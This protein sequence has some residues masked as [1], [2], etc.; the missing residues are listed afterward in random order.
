M[1][2]RNKPPKLFGTPLSKCLEDEAQSNVDSGPINRRRAR[3]E[4]NQIVQDEQGRRR[5]HGAFTG[6]FS[7]G[8]YNTV[9]TVQGFQPKSFKSQRGAG[10]RDYASSSFDHLPEDY[11]DEEDFGEFGIAPKKVRLAG[12]FAEGPASSASKSTAGLPIVVRDSIGEQILRCMTRN[13]KAG[14]LETTQPIIQ[15]NDYH[16]LGYEPLKPNRSSTTTNDERS[17]RNPLVASTKSGMQLKISGEA[18]GVGVL[19]QDEDGFHDTDE[20][21]YDDITNYDFS[22]LQSSAAKDFGRRQSESRVSGKPPDASDPHHLSGFVLTTDPD[23]MV[24][25]DNEC[26]NYPLPVIEDGWKIPVRNEP[27]LKPPCESDL[28]KKNID[29]YKN[30]VSSLDNK[31]TR[32]EF[33]PSKRVHD[34]ESRSGLVPYSDLK[35]LVQPNVQIEVPPQCSNVQGVKITRKV[36]EWRPC[37]LL[38]KRFG[39]ENP[40]PD[41]EFCGVR[42]SDLAQR[43]ELSADQ[44]KMT[45]EKVSSSDQT[46]PIELRKSIFNVSFDNLAEADEVQPVE[47]EYEPQ[48][49]E[50]G[51]PEGGNNL[52]GVYQ[53]D[54]TGRDAGEQSRMDH[55]QDPEVVVVDV[56]KKEPE[57]IVLSSGSSGSSTGR[58]SSAKVSSDE[59]ADVYGP[60]L[61]PS[62]QTLQDISRH[63]SSHKRKRHKSKSHKGKRKARSKVDEQ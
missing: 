31:F 36:V 51:S 59:D 50:L 14:C 2:N 12:Q 33:D 19:N 24:M 29:L 3:L 35:A 16:G 4:R 58:S 20:Y 1:D 7:A 39:V 54:A 11:M 10:R 34:I 41:N 13:R 56:P 60:P 6:G 37:G 5:F 8:Y 46:A 62:R 61:P 9:D 45:S 40:Y 15:K 18:F 26:L 53:D 32:S 57:V 21:G 43:D 48:V 38:C 22:R 28:N 23:A 55:D 30:R 25:C 42:P 49:I 17:S 44:P 52:T 47:D 63:S 27:I